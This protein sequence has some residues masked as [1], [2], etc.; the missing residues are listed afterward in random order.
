MNRNYYFYFDNT[1]KTVQ[2]TIYQ[3]LQNNGKEN[4]S[5]FNISSI[6]IKID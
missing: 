5:F 4:R 3:G 1:E 6:I 2:I